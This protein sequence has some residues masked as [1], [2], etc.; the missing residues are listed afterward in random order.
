MKKIIDEKWIDAEGKTIHHYHTEVEKGKQP[1]GPSNI[2][3]IELNDEEEEEEELFCCHRETE[4]EENPL[5]DLYDELED[6]AD[7]LLT[8]GHHLWQEKE[9]RRKKSNG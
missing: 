9:D 3:W 1:G 4:S 8:I 7:R 5:L 6:L 2:R